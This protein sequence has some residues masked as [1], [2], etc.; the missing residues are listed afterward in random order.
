MS[1][2]RSQC[3]E[4]SSP[5]GSDADVST[6]AC[7]SRAVVGASSPVRQ[8]TWNSSNNGTGRSGRTAMSARPA[9]GSACQALSQPMPGA[10]GDLVEHPLDL[11]GGVGDPPRPRS[12]GRAVG[13][14]LVVGRR[15]VGAV[16]DEHR[17][18]VEVAGVRRLSAPASRWPG[19][20]ATWSTGDAGERVRRDPVGVGDRSAD[21][22]GGE[23]AGAHAVEDPQRRQPVGA[24]HD[25]GVGG[26]E[27][28]IARITARSLPW[29]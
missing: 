1:D 27:A 11:D 21:D 2:P 4:C 7:T 25:V 26:P 16:D 28:P 18:A 13:L 5:V 14:D 8:T 6:S 9:A 12:D 10:D 23:R 24:D 29:Q 15:R 22:A 17:L 3:A 19:G 20:T